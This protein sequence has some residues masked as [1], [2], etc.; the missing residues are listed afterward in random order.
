MVKGSRIRELREAKGL[1]LADAAKEVGIS[2]NMMLYI[3]KGLRQPSVES[4]KNIADYYDVSAD[5]LLDRNG[6]AEAA[7][8]A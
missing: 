4:L 1:T 7:T 2:H 8:T 5:Y 6:D 3:E